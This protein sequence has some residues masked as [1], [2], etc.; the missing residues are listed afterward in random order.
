MIF[1]S[2]NYENFD[3]LTEEEKIEFTVFYVLEKTK[4]E[5]PK[6][7]FFLNEAK[8]NRDKENKDYKTK[9]IDYLS[10]LKWKNEI[11]QKVKLEK[12][13]EKEVK[14]K[15]GIREEARK[16][17]KEFEGKNARKDFPFEIFVQWPH[18]RKEIKKRNIRRNR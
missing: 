18:T 12:F 17:W 6:I 7:A 4:H 16:R 15:R 10:V 2:D 1:D 13:L 5:N 11:S 8:K 14:R 9:K 3:D